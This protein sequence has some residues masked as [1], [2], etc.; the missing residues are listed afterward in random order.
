M[1]LTPLPRRNVFITSVLFPL[2]RQR[3][4]CS[5]IFKAL[6][7]R[8]RPPPSPDP[9]PSS[10]CRR[11][12]LPRGGRPQGKARSRTSSP[13]RVPRH[14]LPARR[15]PEGAAVCRRHH[16]RH[17][18]PPL[19]EPSALPPSA[20]RAVAPL[21]LELPLLLALPLH[22]LLQLPLGPR[23][24]ILRALHGR[25]EAR[26]RRTP[27]AHGS[28]PHPQPRREAGTRRS[29]GST[30]AVAPPPPAASSAGSCAAT[31]PRPRPPPSPMGPCC[32]LAA[33]RRDR[34]VSVSPVPPRAG[35]CRLEKRVRP[36]L[37][38]HGTGR[39][40]GSWWGREAFPLFAREERGRKG[41]G[42]RGERAPSSFLSP[43]VTAELLAP[44]ACRGRASCGS[45]FTREK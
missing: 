34:L 36:L 45:V 5:P 38:P 1:A 26:D 8:T 17:P 23:I 14:H 28:A 10:S 32:A 40:L 39:E 44:V 11:P 2:R 4:G 33:A 31:A 37:S 21:T 20:R 7:W 27:S 15:A 6:R 13:L 43:A 3:K 41:S 16:H 19:P 9:P 30:G 18:S 25:P 29:S 12:G 22:Q 35:P 24:L 42:F